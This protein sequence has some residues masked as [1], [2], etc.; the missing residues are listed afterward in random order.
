MLMDLCLS[1]VDEFFD[2]L[3]KSALVDGETLEA[4]KLRSDLPDNAKALATMM[5]REGVITLYQGNR[6]LQGKFRG[7]HVGSYKILNMLSEGKT[8]AV[9]LAEHDAM[10]RYVAL[11]VVK[12]NL[13]NC[14]LTQER[15]NREARITANLNHPHIVRVYDFAEE[16]GLQ[17]LIMEYVEGKTLQQMLNTTGPLSPEQAVEYIRQ[18][19]HGLE[20]AHNQGIIHRDMKPSNII[21]DKNGKAR[22]LDMG[23]SR[24]SDDEKMNITKMYDPNSVVGTV[25]FIS[26]EQTLG[27]EY[28]CRC[29]V[30]SLGATLFTL[31]A[32]KP[33][34]QGTSYQVLMAHQMDEV[35]SLKQFNPAV[36]SALQAIINKMMAKAPAARYQS[37]G[38]VIEALEKIQLHRTGVKVPS[39]PSKP[40][41][42]PSRPSLKKMS[43]PSLTLEVALA[44]PVR[45]PRS[46]SSPVPMASAGYVEKQPKSYIIALIVGGALAG[47]LLCFLL[48][49][50]L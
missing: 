49:K 28:D 2:V 34:F 19:S 48:Y 25:E 5:V 16:N 24:F 46:P 45:N 6:L 50:L 26:P 22:I 43:T 18:V 31:I 12:Q 37:V 27:E 44:E 32:G 40:P 47:L 21:I 3:E 4:W 33:P 14:K 9:F 23:H 35:P 36:P 30:Y 20:H 1:G 8:D 41:V 13:S 10:D 42:H 39:L 17:Y 29:D 38:E 7:F 15:F 11:K